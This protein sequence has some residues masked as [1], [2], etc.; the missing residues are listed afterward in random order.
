MGKNA[1]FTVETPTTILASAPSGG[2]AFN[3]TMDKSNSKS[4]V[5]RTII[6]PFNFE[7]KLK[8]E[9][10]NLKPGN[11]ISSQR[12]T[13]FLG[14]TKIEHPLGWRRL[15]RFHT[16]GCHRDHLTLEFFIHTPGWQIVLQSRLV[17]L[18]GETVTVF[19][20]IKVRSLD[21]LKG[22][23]L[24]VADQAKRPLRR[25]GHF[26]DELGTVGNRRLGRSQAALDGTVDICAGSELFEP[27]VLGEK[28]LR[29]LQHRGV[30]GSGLQ[31]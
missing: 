8:P 23:F 18:L 9:T 2:S 14:E 30:D 1:T 11:Y 21:K 27:V 12:L 26:G 19:A 15:N 5:R 17:D 28:V 6:I 20:Q 31:S 25:S 24:I 4:L 7:S 13:H 29:D 3:I 16:L 10:R 22:I